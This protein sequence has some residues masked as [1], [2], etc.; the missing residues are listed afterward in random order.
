MTKWDEKNNESVYERCGLSTCANEVNCGV[1]EWIKRKTLQWFG[2]VKRMGSGEFK[3]VYESE[4]EGHNRTG[5]PIRRWKDK[6]E[7]Y[8]GKIGINGRGVLEEARR[9]CWDRE[10]WKPFCRGHPP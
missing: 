2:C 8:L 10:R 7:E 3:T 4:L 5:R 1:V 9:V 6:V